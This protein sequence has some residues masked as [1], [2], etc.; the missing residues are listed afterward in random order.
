MAMI[1][2]AS[3]VDHFNLLAAGENYLTP[4]RFQYTLGWDAGRIELAP[5]VDSAPWQNFPNGRIWGDQTD[6]QWR[7]RDD[8]WH[9]VLL[10]ES[11]E[12]PIPEIFPAAHQK[13]LTAIGEPHEVFLW[14]EYD[15]GAQ[16]W[17]EIKVPKRFDYHSFFPGQAESP[18]RVRL[19]VHAY[20]CSETRSLWEF[21]RKVP[22][23]FVSR[24]YR[25]GKLI[26]E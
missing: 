23:P 3:A 8:G 6:L 18:A 2:Y 17:I 14:G 9:F 12:S 11:G 16:N 26:G 24:V 21:G 1:T 25:Y 22:L 19:Q 13:T 4:A 5:F 7:R 20:E 10:A 15:K